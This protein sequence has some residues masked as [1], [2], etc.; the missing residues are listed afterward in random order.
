MDI[1]GGHSLVAVSCTSY[2]WCMAVDTR[3]YEMTYEGRSTALLG[4]W[5]APK[6][7]STS[8]QP[9]A[10]SCSVGP[11]DVDGC[12][13]VFS[14]GRAITYDDGTWGAKVLVDTA[15]LTALSC[16]A[17]DFCFAGSQTGKVVAWVGNQQKWQDLGAIG[18]GG[19]AVKA[20]SCTKA[21]LCVAVTAN[22]DAFKGT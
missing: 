8:G 13:V 16:G 11:Q 19:A 14:G 20:L 2:L 15:P 7:F 6:Q 1:D 3:G 10:L 5:Q 21:A 4:T 9:T 22:G 18:A 12:I 17:W